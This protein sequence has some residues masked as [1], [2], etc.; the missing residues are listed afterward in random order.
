MTYILYIH[1]F[2]LRAYYEMAKEIWCTLTQIH[3]FVVQKGLNWIESCPQRLETSLA[4]MTFLA[5]SKI[6]LTN[7]IVVQFIKLYRMALTR[8]ICGCNLKS[9]CDNLTE[10]AQ[11]YSIVHSVA[12]VIQTSKLR[13]AYRSNLGNLPH[14][15]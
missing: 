5:V 4:K 2:A 6:L 15:S 14:L 10:T 12:Y 13:F 11:H 7:Y 3:C 8:R 1:I 9:A